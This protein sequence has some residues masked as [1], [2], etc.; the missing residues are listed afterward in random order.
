LN[1]GHDGTFVERSESFVAKNGLLFEGSAEL[2]QE[3]VAAA[4]TTH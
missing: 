3:F 4:L 2:D 1:F